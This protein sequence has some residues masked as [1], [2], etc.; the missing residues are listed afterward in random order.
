MMN[1]SQNYEPYLLNL[2][3]TQYTLDHKYHHTPHY[4]PGYHKR[5]SSLKHPIQK[6]CIQDCLATTCI[7]S[8]ASPSFM[9]TQSQQLDN[10]NSF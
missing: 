2:H 3:K 10:I 9:G 1:Q 8:L 5:E 7:Q 6:D 4:L